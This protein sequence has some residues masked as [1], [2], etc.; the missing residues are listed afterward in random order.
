MATNDGYSP[1][2]LGL[3]ALQTKDAITRAHNLSTELLGYVAYLDATV[4]PALGGPEGVKEGDIWHSETSG[5]YYRAFVDTGT[6]LYF[7][8]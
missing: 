5:I 1:Y 6:L 3:T 4:A 7:E 8:V 2:P